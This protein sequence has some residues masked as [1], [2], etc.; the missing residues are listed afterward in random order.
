MFWRALFTPH[1][2]ARSAHR[3]YRRLG[4]KRD[5]RRSIRI[6]QDMSI[7]EL[8][9][10][11]TVLQVFLQGVLADVGGGAAHGGDGRLVDDGVAGF[12][13]GVFCHVVGMGL[14]L[15]WMVYGEVVGGE[16]EAL[17]LCRLVEGWSCLL[18]R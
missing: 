5:A 17:Y 2:L 18:A 3:I 4:G 15:V 11:K 7:L 6:K 1:L 14:G 9:G 16:R 10:I 13:L 8:L 12:G